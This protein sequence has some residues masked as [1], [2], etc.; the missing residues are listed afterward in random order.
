[1][2]TYGRDDDLTLESSC[3]GRLRR[4]IV[5]SWK[6]TD[7]SP[8]LNFTDSIFCILGVAAGKNKSEALE[9][10]IENSQDMLEDQ[11]KV[12]T[13]E[14]SLVNIA[15]SKGLDNAFKQLEYSDPESIAEAV[16]TIYREVLNRRWN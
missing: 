15:N 9:D 2:G 14:V 11:Y 13:K 10:F 1:M 6:M 5:V 4:Y 16:E 3:K 8:Y 7:I 12:D